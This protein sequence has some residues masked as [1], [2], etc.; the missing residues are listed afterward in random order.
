[1]FLFQNI[2][3]RIFKLLNRNTNMRINFINL[4]LSN[5]LH[6]LGIIFKT[7]PHQTIEGQLDGIIKIALPIIG[8]KKLE[9]DF[10]GVLK[11]RV[12]GHGGFCSPSDG[13]FIESSFRG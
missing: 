6:N 10:D 1:M 9:M 12:G 2:G 11:D 13:V 4:L 7:N 8:I 5:D 3:I